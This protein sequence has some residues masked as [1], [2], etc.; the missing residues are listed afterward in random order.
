MQND[1]ALPLTTCLSNYPI[2]PGEHMGRNPND[3]GFSIRL[4]PHPSLR[5]ELLDLLYSSQDVGRNLPILKFRLPILECGSPDY[6]VRS[7][8]HIGWNREAD[9]LGGF[10]INDEFK[11]SWLLDGKVGGLCTFEDFIHV[12][13]GTAR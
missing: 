8:E 9:L 3:S 13:G 11:L 1:T 12:T 5:T 6:S 2:R 7:R 10:E 4:T